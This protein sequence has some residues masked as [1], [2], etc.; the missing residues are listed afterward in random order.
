MKLQYRRKALFGD[1]GSSAHSGRAGSSPA[2]RTNKK[3]LKLNGFKAFS[4]A[5]GALF[6]LTFSLYRLDIFG[7][8]KSYA[9]I[10]LQTPAE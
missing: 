5:A 6:S 7:S 1:S 2:S 4:F 10:Y 8:V 3:A 9:Q